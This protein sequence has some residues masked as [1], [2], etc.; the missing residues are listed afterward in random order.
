MGKKNKKRSKNS[1]NKRGV[2]AVKR[3]CRIQ[4]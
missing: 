4:R 3:A 1:K 2:V